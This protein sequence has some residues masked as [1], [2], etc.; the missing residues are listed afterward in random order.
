MKNGTEF[1]FV[2]SR[3]TQSLHYPLPILPLIPL[4]TSWKSKILSLVISMLEVQY[5]V[6]DTMVM[7]HMMKMMVEVVETVVT[8][9]QFEMVVVS[10]LFQ[11][12]NKFILHNG[13]CTTFHN[14]FR[15][16]FFQINT[17]CMSY[18]YHV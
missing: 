18:I 2:P 1:S 3:G 16:I 9:H 11:K 15:C 13:I 14:Q 8:A 7:A 10:L 12:G 4:I 5:Y 6:V 17:T